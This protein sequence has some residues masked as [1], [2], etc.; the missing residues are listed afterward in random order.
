MKCTY[1]NEFITNVLKLPVAVSKFLLS[2]SLASSYE[3]STITLAPSHNATLFT[4]FF[5][6][7][8]V[9]IVSVS[10]KSTTTSSSV[11]KNNEDHKK[12]FNNFNYLFLIKI[13][14]FQVLSLFLEFLIAC[15]PFA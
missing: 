7:A 9:Q 2:N 14:Q 4:S 5:T 15:Y 13:E 8:F 12:G 1:L 11:Y 6:S 10:K 3:N